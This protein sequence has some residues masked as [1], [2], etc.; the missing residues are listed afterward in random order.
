MGLIEKYQIPE[1]GAHPFLIKDSWQVSKLNYQA[2]EYQVGKLEYFNKHE[3]TNRALALLKGKTVLVFTRDFGQYNVVAMKRGLAYNIPKKTHYALV[4][5][6]DSE[7]F[8][9]EPPNTDQIDTERNHLTEEHLQTI[10]EK[11]TKEFQ[12]YH[13]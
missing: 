10:R 4:L 5:E 13:E 3:H 12:N 2:K 6:E 9:V 8:S 1:T 11:I 7:L